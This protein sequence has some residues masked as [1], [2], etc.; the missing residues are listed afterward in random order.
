[1]SGYE[2]FERPLYIIRVS[3]FFTDFYHETKIIVYIFTD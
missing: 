3:I 1:M 2:L